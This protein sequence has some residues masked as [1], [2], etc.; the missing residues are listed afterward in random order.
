[1]LG[2]ILKFLL[3]EKWYD[4]LYCFKDLAARMHLIEMTADRAAQG[5]AALTLGRTNGS[6]TADGGLEKWEFRLRSQWGEDGI[7]H[8]IFDCVGITNRTFVEFGVQAGR[9]C[10]AAHLALSERWRGL[11]IEGDPRL[12]GWTQEYYERMLGTDADRI[13]VACAFVTVENIDSVLAEN[14]MSGPIDLLSIDIDGN[15]YWIWT[16]ITAVTPRVLVIEYNAAFGPERAVTIPYNANFRW[17]GSDSDLY[18]GASL[19]ALTKLAARKGYALVG[20]GSNGVN[21]FFVQRQLAKGELC[22]VAVADAFRPRAGLT[23][24]LPLGEH[25]DLVGSVPLVTV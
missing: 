10:N 25:L 5:L 16:A 2:Q 8:H 24:R 9:E 15:D 7:L 12:A 4:N 19:L 17:S 22:E 1:M 3:P 18:F 21:A 14:G 6:G 20:C 23:G 13:R 11:F